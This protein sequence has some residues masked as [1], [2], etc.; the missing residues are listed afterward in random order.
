VTAVGAASGVAIALAASRL[1]EALLFGVP[2]NDPLTFAGVIAV[3][4]VVGVA[5]GWWPARRATAIDPAAALR[6]E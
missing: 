1:M 2:A 6:A 3:I 5:A 4:A